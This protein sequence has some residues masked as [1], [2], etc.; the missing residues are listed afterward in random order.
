MSDK[1]IDTYFWMKGVN[2]HFVLKWTS[3]VKRST[4]IIVLMMYKDQSQIFKFAHT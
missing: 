4:L 2:N 3:N 1:E